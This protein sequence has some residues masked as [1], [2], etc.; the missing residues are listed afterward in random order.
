MRNEALKDRID[1]HADR[2]VNEKN[3][4]GNLRQPGEKARPG[5]GLEKSGR[6]C[7]TETDG[8]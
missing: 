1:Y 4:V 8:R 3:R 2:E 6:A 5:P 7:G